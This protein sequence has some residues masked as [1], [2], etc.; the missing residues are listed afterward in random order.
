MLRM[1][2]R[3]YIR[4]TSMEYANYTAGTYSDSD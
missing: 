3:R 1:E 2:G 4:P